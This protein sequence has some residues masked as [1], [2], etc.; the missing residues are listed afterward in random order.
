MKYDLSVLLAGIRTQNWEQLFFS[1]ERS[2][3]PYSF[4]L[5]AVGPYDPPPNLITKS[6]FK[7]FRDFGS[8]SRCVQIA[9][10]L[11]EGEHLIWMADDGVCTP[12]TLAECISMFDNQTIKEK[13]VITIRYFEGEGNGE[14]PI[15]YWRAKHHGDMQTLEGVKSTFRIAPIG[16]YKTSYFREL[17]GLDC[18]YLHTNMNTH[19]LAFRLQNDGGNVHLSPHTVARFYWSWNGAD[20]KPVQRA[21]HENDNGLFTSEWSQDQSNRIKI[22]YCNWT[23]AENRWK[24]RFG[25]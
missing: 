24:M 1:L 16:M 19:D 7:F 13:D 20:A 15:D 5:I 14:F 10:T 8:P 4:E 11:A 21:Y 17:G 6:N 23:N 18:R 9:S 22:D 25:E 3:E 2:I 12:N